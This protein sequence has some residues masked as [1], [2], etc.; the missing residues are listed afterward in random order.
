MKVTQTDKQLLGKVV[1][2]TSGP[3][4]N[5]QGIALGEHPDKQQG[6]R[7]LVGNI[8]AGN[9]QRAIAVPPH[10]LETVQ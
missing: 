4:R 7:Y 3:H 1:R 8:S 2:I 5:V 10:W 9:P 6:L